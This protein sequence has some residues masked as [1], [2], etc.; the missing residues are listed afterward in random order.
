M[1]AL[2]EGVATATLKANVR[3]VSADSDGAVLVLMFEGSKDPVKLRGFDARE[4]AEWMKLAGKNVSL[5]ITARMVAATQEELKPAAKKKP[6][7]E[8]PHEGPHSF[9]VKRCWKCGEPE[10]ST[11]D[12]GYHMI[13]GGLCNKEGCL[14]QSEA[15]REVQSAALAAEEAVSIDAARAAGVK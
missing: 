8:K 11:C 4:A 5:S 13:E 6:P 10:P 14:W 15:A 12:R 1:T 7:K 9:I 2:I 3:A